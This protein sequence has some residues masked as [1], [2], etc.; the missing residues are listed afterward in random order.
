MNN[1]SQT[2]ITSAKTNKLDS[3]SPRPST[4]NLMN[5]ET[6]TEKMK[7]E[8]LRFLRAHKDYAKQAPGNIDRLCAMQ[9]FTVNKNPETNRKP[10]ISRC[11]L[12][13]YELTKLNP[14]Q[15]AEH[16]K[17]CRYHHQ[18]ISSIRKVEGRQRK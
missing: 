11:S 8:A 4:P 6:L 14:V 10:A 3:N 1:Q 12:S 16:Q 2:T 15:R 18:T 5:D 13:R 7:A 9:V 17:L